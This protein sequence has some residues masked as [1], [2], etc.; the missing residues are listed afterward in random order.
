[1]RVLDL[2]APGRFAWRDVPEPQPAQDE[3]LVRVRYAGVCGTDLHAFAGRQPFLEYP[4]RLGHEL[5]VEPVEADLSARYA[6]NPYLHCGHCQSC[7]LG[8]TNCCESLEVLG[9]HTDGGHAPLLAV[10]RSHLY[11]SAVLSEE[12]MA[13]VEPLVVGHHAVGR[14]QLGE[15]TPTLIVGMGPIGM[16]V[17]LFA[18]HRQAHLVVCEPREDRRQACR[19]MLDLDH[20]LMPGPGLEQ[21]VRNTL[22]GQLP[23]VVMDATGSPGAMHASFGLAAH[24]GRC[25]F[26][27]H[28]PGDYTFHEPDF[29]RREL[30]LVASRN[31]THEDF[32]SVIAALESGEVDA[33]PL[34]THRYRF[35]EAPEVF[36]GLPTMPGLVKA[37][38]AIS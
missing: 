12:V 34:I 24:G 13:L 6:V 4:R 15:G 38:I 22:N 25:V 23:E 7:A 29:H 8:R 18:K 9:V 33:A 35:E 14:A 28:Y 31:G 5:C 2:A 32:V 11:S 21:E 10:P 37:L 16:A 27:G 3:V 36:P 20:V 19:E 1:M 30:T 26:V 17:A